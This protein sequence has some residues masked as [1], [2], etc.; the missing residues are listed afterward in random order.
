MHTSDKALWQGAVD[1]ELTSIEDNSV[2]W[3]VRRTADMKVLSIRRVFVKIR[4]ENEPPLY[5]GRL[6]VR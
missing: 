6:V 3:P 2:L 5:K 4:G 1:R